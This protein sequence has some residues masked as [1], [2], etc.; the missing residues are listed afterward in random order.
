MQLDQFAVIDTVTSKT[1]NAR[2][3]KYMFAN[4]R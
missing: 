3:G 2:F 1:S 4:L